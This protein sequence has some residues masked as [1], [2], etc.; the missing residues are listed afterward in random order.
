MILTLKQHCRSM[1]RV[2]CKFVEATYD[3]GEMKMGQGD[4]IF[5]HE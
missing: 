1:Q 4:I 5:W 2:V 3:V